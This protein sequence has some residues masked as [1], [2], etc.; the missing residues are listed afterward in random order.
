MGYACPA[1]G[2]DRGF[3]GE[4]L[5]RE[6]QVAG[7]LSQSP[8]AATPRWALDSGLAW[9]L[10]RPWQALEHR[11]PAAGANVR[12]NTCRPSPVRGRGPRELWWCRGAASPMGQGRAQLQGSRAQRGTEPGPPSLK[13][14]T[15]VQGG[16]RGSLSCKFWSEVP[17]KVIYLTEPGPPSSSHQGS[18]RGFE[19]WWDDHHGAS[20]S[21]WGCGH[22]LWKP[23][24]QV[25][26]FPEEVPT[27]PSVWAV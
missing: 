27:V 5:S 13:P 8:R 15:Q 19:T 6:A 2:A 14:E 20:P 9:A 3:C 25:A 26:S 4:S 7:P 24:E 16:K 23:R 12:E 11:R 1:P 17:R 10:S 18:Q 21:H 22:T